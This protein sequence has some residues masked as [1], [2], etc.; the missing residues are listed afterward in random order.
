MR[1]SLPRV[2]LL[3]LAGA[4][5][6]VP[7]LAQ[8]QSP[9][10]V[11]SVAPGAS[12]APAASAPE[13]LAPGQPPAAWALAAC[14]ALAR[15]AEAQDPLAQL[16]QAALDGDTDSMSFMAIAVGLLGD[17]ATRA[18]E[19]VGDTWGPGATLAGFLSSTGFAMVDIGT[20]LAEPDP[21]DPEPLRQALGSVITAT[22]SWD[23][24]RDEL[25]SVVASTSLDC[26]TVPVPSAEPVPLSSVAPPTPEPTFL[27]DPDLESQFPKTIDGKAVDPASRTGAELELSSDP[28]DPES[29]AR[30][31]DIEDL[32]ATSGHTLDDI[33]LAFAYVP[34]D[35]GLGASITA[36]RVK[37][38][39]AAALLPELIPLVTVDYLEPVQDSV[40]IDGQTYVRVSDGGFD[41]EGI[42]EVLVP[43]G[44][45]VWAISASD[46]VTAEIVKELPAA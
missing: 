22:T 40:T 11:T 9:A 7:A 16:G 24:V 2:A 36:F 34:T 25:T 29:Q 5:L 45:T 43:R 35:D 19:G 18:L 37:G 41:P 26:T 44:D 46:T 20:A 17:Q 3:A 15:E 23:R 33:S 4:T 6:L 27:G 13:S 14:T 42:Y 1:T 28:G 10:P 31:Q 12:P 21:S 8:A 38:A 32:I 30:L 39:D